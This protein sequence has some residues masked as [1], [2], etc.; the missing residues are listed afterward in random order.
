MRSRHFDAMLLIYLY[1]F[2]C[3]SVVQTITGQVLW[4]MCDLGLFNLVATLYL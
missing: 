4:Q 2:V 3:H 1:I